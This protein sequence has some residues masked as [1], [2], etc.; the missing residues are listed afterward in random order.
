[1]KS[2]ILKFNKNQR[3]HMRAAWKSPWK[4]VLEGR[5]KHEYHNMCQNAMVKTKVLI[6][7][8]HAVPRKFLILYKMSDI[9]IS[10]NRVKQN[11]GPFFANVFWRTITSCR[12]FYKCD[13]TNLIYV[14][15]HVDKTAKEE[16]HWQMCGNYFKKK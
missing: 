7:E 12:V 1:M 8:A 13:S 9:F 6:I 10:S 3:F 4:A 11:L 2:K 14:I 16:L 5:E 15:N